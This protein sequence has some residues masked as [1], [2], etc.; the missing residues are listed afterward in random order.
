MCASISDS[1]SGVASMLRTLGSNVAVS[2]VSRLLVEAADTF[3][4]ILNQEGHYVRK[5]NAAIG[6]RLERRA[7]L[8]LQVVGSCYPQRTREDP[9]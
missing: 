1:L 6:A 4:L 2:N 9:G 5:V 3:Q 7:G 8:Q